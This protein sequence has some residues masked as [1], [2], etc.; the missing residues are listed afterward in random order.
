MHQIITRCIIQSSITGSRKSTV[1]NMLNNFYLLSPIGISLQYIVQY[2][3][4]IIFCTVI[5]KNKFNIIVCLFK[6]RNY[7]TLDILLYSIYWN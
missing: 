3:N 1:N 6:Q 7:T 5:Y 2:C 4:T